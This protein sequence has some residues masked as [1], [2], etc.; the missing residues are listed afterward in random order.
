MTLVGRGK[1]KR[2]G[3]SGAVPLIAS[4]NKRARVAV[5]PAMFWAVH[6]YQAASLIF[7]LEISKV[8]APLPS[9]VMCTS[10]PGVIDTP[11]CNYDCINIS[12]V[13]YTLGGFFCVHQKYKKH[14]LST[15]NSNQLFKLSK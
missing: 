13:I 14:Q 1:F 12:K 4:T 8:E 9:V 7:D 11:S 6:W 3:G 2:L 15:V 5:E 10:G